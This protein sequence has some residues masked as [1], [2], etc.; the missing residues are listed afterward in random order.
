M[1]HNTEAMLLAVL[2]KVLGHDYEFDPE[3]SSQVFYWLD[4]TAMVRVSTTIDD[5]VRQAYEA[6]AR[7]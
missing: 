6:C 1:D 3:D 4:E 5:L 2:G 7:D